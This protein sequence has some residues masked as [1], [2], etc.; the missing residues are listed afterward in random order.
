MEPYLMALTSEVAGQ[1]LGIV[2]IRT[3]HPIVKTAQHG[4]T[5]LP[6]A[7]VSGRKNCSRLPEKKALV[8]S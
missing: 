1:R 2:G 4:G 6:A 5:A 8:M 3:L 7:C